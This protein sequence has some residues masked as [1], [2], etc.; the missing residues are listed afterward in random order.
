MLYVLVKL[1]FTYQ[2]EQE[3]KKGFRGRTFIGRFQATLW[4]WRGSSP[5]VI[6]NWL[7][8]NLRQ[9]KEVVKKAVRLELF[10]LC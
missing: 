5:R 10:F 8:N 2:C 9:Y 7:D 4:Q 1:L 3:D 6:P